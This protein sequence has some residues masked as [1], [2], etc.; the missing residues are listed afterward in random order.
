ML[1]L[2]TGGWR[3]YER[4]YQS[5]LQLEVQVKVSLTTQFLDEFIQDGQKGGRS[6]AKALIEAAHCHV[7][8]VKPASSPNINYKIQVYAN[9]TGLAKLYAD[10]S[11]VGSADHLREFIRG[12]NMED[13]LCEFV[14][15]GNGKECSDVKIKGKAFYSTFEDQEIS[16]ISCSSF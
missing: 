16:N 7:R 15:A 8:E 6:A 13:T 9:V 12:F 10:T 4:E 5:F 11:I 2:S 14:D 1:R 3:S